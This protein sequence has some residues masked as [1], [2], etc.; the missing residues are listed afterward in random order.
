[1]AKLTSIVCA[2]CTKQATEN[3]QDASDRDGNLATPS[4]SDER[5][6]SSQQASVVF[7]TV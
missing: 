2:E 6:N 1:M 3:H 7:G 4:I 5:P